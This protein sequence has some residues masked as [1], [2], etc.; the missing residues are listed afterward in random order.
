MRIGWSDDGG[1]H[2]TERMAG[3]K[4][5][6]EDALPALPLG[7]DRTTACGSTPT[8]TLYHGTDQVYASFDQG[9]SW[10]VA[11]ACQD[12]LGK[13]TNV[14][15]IEVAPSNPNIAYAGT[16]GGS[17]LRCD[18]AAGP[19]AAF[20]DVGR[21]IFPEPDKRRWLSGIAIDPND[22]NTLY[23]S[24]LG[25]G[26]EVGADQVWMARKDA[27]NAWT[28]TRYSDGLSNAP[29]A[30][31]LFA[32]SGR[33]YVATDAGVYHRMPGASSWQPATSGMPRAPVVDLALD[34]AGSRLIAA[35]HGRG[36]FELRLDGQCDPVVLSVRDNLLDIGL[37]PSP[38]GEDNPVVPATTV[39]HYES[40]DIKVDRPPF[41][42][43]DDVV[44]GVE[45]DHVEHPYTYPD[46]HKV[47]LIRHGLG[48]DERPLTGAR[49]RV[50]V[51]V[52]NRGS[53]TDNGPITVKLLYA[54]A[55]AG[56]PLLPS[57]FWTA[58]P[59]N[60]F[61]QTNWRI[62]GTRSISRL[63][64]GVPAVL[65][66][67]WNVPENAPKHCCLLA[68]VHSTADPLT[69][70]TETDVDAL[71]RANRRA[72]QR[73]VQVLQQVRVEAFELL[74]AAKRQS[75]AIRFEEY[76]RDHR[77][78]VLFVLPRTQS[79]SLTGLIQVPPTALDSML[80]RAVEA[81]LLTPRETQ[82]LRAIED[83]M[84][85]RLEPTAARAELRHEPGAPPAALWVFVEAAAG[86]PAGA[87]LLAVNQVDAK[88]GILGGS[89]FLYRDASH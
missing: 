4:G 65:K 31:I 16:R 68:L 66:F 9:V 57:D 73:N 59:G 79:I 20:A 82:R 80:V 58:F 32:P 6:N 67:D 35:T 56:L 1:D 10:E 15:A 46:G 69:P 25:F 74:I 26:P 83:P 62:I 47:E 23:V 88:G 77:P 81:D 84:I 63:R 37:E 76:P 29:A 70:Q 28:F 48:P 55:A 17:L 36:A 14:T 54:P 49:N 53:S 38:E 45:F 44:D 30:A 60:S 11:S 22:P 34:R 41:A 78:Q 64:P 72:T 24:F 61:D 75:A 18:N 71:V 7:F 5:S 39:L 50:Y 43:V 52:H 51:Q 87:P 33:L 27:S 3:I 89:R 12:A 2:F 42:E 85:L 40:P 21:R 8:T 13:Q 86:T 19:G